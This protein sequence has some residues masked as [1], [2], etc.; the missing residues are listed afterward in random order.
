MRRLVVG[1]I[2]GNLPALHSV[3][4]KANYTFA[5]RLYFLGDYIDRKP[6][7]KEVVEFIIQLPKK[8]CLRGNHDQFLIDHFQQSDR[9]RPIE[10]RW[11]RNG[12]LEALESYGIG[13]QPLSSGRYGTTGEVPESHLEFFQSTLPY[14]IT[15]DGIGLVHGGFDLHLHEKPD[16]FF[17]WDRIMWRTAVKIEYLQ[18][19]SRLEFRNGE[20]D[21]KVELPFEVADSYPCFE[22]L[23][24]IFIGHT[25]LL[26]HPNQEICYPQKR[27]NVWNIDTGA[28][29]SGP[30][31]IIDMDTEEYWQSETN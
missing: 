13:I 23:P 11:Y 12:G 18:S 7:S 5:D 29:Y 15:P 22:Q 24:K 1:D 19:G 8:I 17:W 27:L 16:E 21:E 25:N 4:E 30:L 2:H 6:Y 3:L 31:T 14:Y 9:I 28:A 20:E 10:P 26:S